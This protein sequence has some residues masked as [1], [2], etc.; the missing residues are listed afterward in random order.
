MTNLYVLASNIH[1]LTD[2]DVIATFQLVNLTNTY[3]TLVFSSLPGVGKIQALLML[4]L[5]NSSNMLKLK[6]EQVHSIAGN[7]KQWASVQLSW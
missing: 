6:T 1:K 3:L 5:D 2:S 7:Y 4:C